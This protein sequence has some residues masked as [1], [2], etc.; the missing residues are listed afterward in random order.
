MKLKTP[1]S[2][3]GGKQTMAKLIV[4]LIPKHRLYCEPFAGGLAVFWSKPKSEMEV[5]N[6]TNGAVIKFYKVLKSDFGILRHLILETPVSRKVHRQTEFVLKYSEHF[7]SIKVAHAFWVQ[8]NLSFGAMIGAG[9]GY[10][11]TKNTQVSK[12]RNKK[13]NF[14]KHLTTRLENVDIECND[15]IKVI[16]S[17]DCEDA[18]FYVDPPYFNSDC[19]HY[20][21]YTKADFIKLLECLSQIKGKFLLSSYPSDVL[22]EYVGRN[23]WQCHSKQSKIAVTHLTNK[24]KTECLTANYDILSLL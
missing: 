2:Y 3:Y 16:K 6:D 22:S 13:L 15:A 5:I 12:I 4:S 24:V 17:R 23:G 19:G 9:Y 21:G 11:R 20:E 1:I 10:A 7:D 14:T 18:F 8:T